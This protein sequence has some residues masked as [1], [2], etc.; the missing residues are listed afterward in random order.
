MK[1]SWQII[2]LLVT[3]EFLIIATTSYT[4]IDVSALCTLFFNVVAISL[5]IY[6]ARLKAPFALAHLGALF[7]IF[8]HIT[9]ELLQTSEYSGI[10]IYSELIKTSLLAIGTLLCS[11]VMVWQHLQWQTNE[12]RTLTLNEESSALKNLINTLS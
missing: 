12:T 10:G 11:L 9:Y 2:I 3:A 6:L 8:A 7:P 1:T 5:L 4:Q